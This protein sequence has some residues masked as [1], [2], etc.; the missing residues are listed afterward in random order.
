[1]AL[2]SYP[3][4]GLRASLPRGAAGPVQQDDPLTALQTFLAGNGGSTTTPEPDPSEG[5]TTE[6][7]FGNGTKPGS[8]AGMSQ[9]TLNTP[10][11]KD[12]AAEA[13]DADAR[14]AEKVKQAD[15]LNEFFNPQAEQQRAE[16]TANKAAIATAPIEAKGKYDLAAEEIKANAAR[17][18]ASAKANP[19][20]GSFGDGSNPTVDYWAQNAMRDRSMLT[21]IPAAL[22]GAVEARMASMGGSPQAPT[23]QAK[24]MAETAKDLLDVIKQAGGTTGISGLAQNLQQKGLFNPLVGPI[25]RFAAEHG[26]GT[27]MGVDDQTASDIG[28]F[29]DITDLL[30]SGL[31]RAHAGARGAGNSEMAARFDKLL[32]GIGDFPTFSGQLGAIE[33]I[34]RQYAS[35]LYPEY[36]ENALGADPYADPNYNPR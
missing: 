21:Q 9:A 31:S 19:F 13:A 26:A 6:Y 16:E 10:Y 34:L 1:M 12:Q 28:Y 15:L 33:T 36:G 25:R 35:K 11:E 5:T 3:P 32:G 24:Q 22:R 8:F 20:G 27:L 23:N 17:D 7:D 29:N 30:K 2:T 4:A 14:D 18:V